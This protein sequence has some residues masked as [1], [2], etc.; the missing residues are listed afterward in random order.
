MACPCACWTLQ[1]C[2]S[3]LLLQVVSVLLDESSI[4]SAS[5]EGFSAAVGDGALHEG[6]LELIGSLGRA[7][8][9]GAEAGEDVDEVS[10]GRIKLR[11]RWSHQRLKALRTN[12]KR[13]PNG[14]VISEKCSNSER[15][16]KTRGSV[17]GRRCEEVSKSN[18]TLSRET[19]VVSCLGGAHRLQRQS[20]ESSGPYVSS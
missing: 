4:S 10:A 9:T 19:T 20:S 18:I 12:P 3:P 6:A 11:V 2:R 13:T 14:N 15:P 16:G 8:A 7:V 17:L 5:A 1:R